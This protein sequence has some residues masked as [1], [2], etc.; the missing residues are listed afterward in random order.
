MIYI[1]FLTATAAKKNNHPKK[2]WLHGKI[3]CIIVVRLNLTS[4]LK[5]L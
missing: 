4:Y 3:L 5:E 2:G 1:D